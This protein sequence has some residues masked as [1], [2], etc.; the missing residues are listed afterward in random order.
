M[1]KKDIQAIVLKLQQAKYQY[2]T[3]GNS[4]LSDQE[5]D[6]LEEQL[7]ALAPEHSYFQT[8]G[9]PMAFVAP[10]E[11]II[12]KAPMLSA[13]KCK[14]LDE[15]QKWLTR[16]ALPPETEFLIEPKIDGLS[17][18][19]VYEQGR[20]VYVA[21]RG[22]G[23]IGQD[24]SHIAQYIDN[25][26]KNLPQPLS[27][28]VRGEL[29]LPQNTEFDTKGKP[30]RNNCVGLINRKDQQEDLVFVHFSVYQVLGDDHET[31][32]AA[33]S[34]LG[35]L[36]FDIVP[37]R[38]ARAF[39]DIEDYYRHYLEELRYFWPYETDGLIIIVNDRRLHP[40]IDARWVVDHHHHYLVAFKPPAH[41]KETQLKRVEWQVS[42]QGNLIPVAIF[43]PIQLG[44]AT[45]ERASLHNAETVQKLCL[46]LGDTLLIERAN[47]V[48]P[49]VKTNL[50][51]HENRELA[52]SLIPVQ[53][54]SCAGPLTHQGV[55]VHC[56]NKNCPDR[57]VEKV[58][59]WVNC[60][61]MEN[62]AEATIRQLFEKNL[63]RSVVDLYHITAE[64]LAK[65]EGFAQKKIENFLREVKKSRFMTAQEF[66]ARL[67]IPLVQGKALQKLG[68]FAMSDFWDF[69][70]EQYVI[71][72]NLI[73]WRDDE[74]NYALVQELCKV[75]HIEDVQ[76]EKVDLPQVCCTGS[77]PLPRNELGKVLA[78]LGYAISDSVTKETKLLL[79]E[80]PQGNSSKL[81]KARKMNIPIQSYE[82]FFKEKGQ[83]F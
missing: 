39:E 33:I 43:E 13:D 11:K 76:K 22:D 69:H 10:S 36:G 54:P 64:D 25:I 23:K 40:Q 32:Y 3:Q 31:E 46:A 72:R 21:T 37:L 55:H 41:S 75:L 7:R 30:L 34:A 38:I 50:S 27:I 65:L 67:G 9:T 56:G 12:H 49:Y 81:V 77:G 29:Y 57:Q 78:S 52:N 24:V 47:D 51:H 44:G 71:G 80:N 45:L 74:D 28:E 53:C 83:L 14:N 5:F 82:E 58:L 60:C 6:Q 59:Y 68:I 18:T 63:L 2:Y 8:V 62:I 48:I 61:Q 17:A 15:L 26:P 1:D 79:C 4:P 70:D 16:L 66:V 35:D 73:A 20:L 19:C 42:R